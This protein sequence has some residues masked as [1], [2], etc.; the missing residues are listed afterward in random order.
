MSNEKSDAKLAFDAGAALHEFSEIDGVKVA[1]IPKDYNVVSLERLMGVPR[2]KRGLVSLHDAQSFSAY[3]KDHSDESSRIYLSM[4]EQAGAVFFT[5]VL[6]HH[7]SDEA[8]WGD[9][10]AHYA[11]RPT[12]EWV[13]WL[14]HD[15]MKMHQVQ[16]AEFLE[17]N[18]KQ[19]VA[20]EAVKVIELALDFQAKTEVDFTSAVKLSNGNVTLRYQ[21]E[22]KH[23]EMQVPAELTLGIRIF[24]GG[25]H[26]ELK[27][28]L[29][30]R[31]ESRRLIFWYELVTPHLLVRDA[32]DSIRHMIEEQTNVPLLRGDAPVYPQ[33][34]SIKL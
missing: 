3:V 14:G 6:D 29:R 22:T 4:N 26:Y 32:V 2:R 12:P 17:E 34:D 13:N 16:F 18:A 23:G 33:T 1:V 30:Y 25:G 10:R 11:P 20:P 21:E 19:I 7:Y 28:R 31:L 9:H 8:R 24:E 5:C 27:A 15:R